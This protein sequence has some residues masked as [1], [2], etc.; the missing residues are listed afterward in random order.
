MPSL[1]KQLVEHF[2]VM[3]YDRRGAFSPGPGASRGS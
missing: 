1:A 2:T 3:V